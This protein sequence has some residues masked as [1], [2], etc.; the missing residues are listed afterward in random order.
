MGRKISYLILILMT[1]YL[2]VMYDSTWLL[3]LLGLELLLAA[4]LFLMSFYFQKNIRIG[5]E[6]NIPVASRNEEIPL[7]VW[8]E[9]RGILPISEIH[10]VIG[11][12]NQ[13]GK[14]REQYILEERIEGRSQKKIVMQAK[15]SYSGRLHFFVH[16]AHTGDYLRL[17]CRKLKCHSE[18]YVNILPDITEIPVRLTMRTLNF[19]VEGDEYEQN[20]S[21]DDPSEIFQIREFRGGDR[22]QRV[23]WKMSA[24][25]DELMTKEYSMPKGC[26]VL[27]LLDCCHPKINMENMDRFLETA[28]SLCFSMLEADCPHYAV[29]YDGEAQRVLRYIIR[30]DEDIY[31]ML[32]LLMAAP[33]C[34]Q[35]YD[36]ESACLSRWQEGTY[37]TVLRLKL[38]G[39]FICNGK[40]AGSFAEG[41]LDKVLSAFVLEV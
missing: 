10:I 22:M 34:E 18:I 5:L 28:A 40:L 33:V 13:Y 38:D 4:G 21:G 23:H 24:R 19:P 39:N 6:M 15:S 1:V 12:E 7:E 20:R 3:P 29:W 2:E 35:E 30:K 14:Y 11:Y 32:D 36:L 27:L 41:S 17:F 8:I 16:K 9:N 37:S 25:M 31:V 26:K